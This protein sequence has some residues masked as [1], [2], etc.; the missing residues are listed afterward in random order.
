MKKINIL[1]QSAGGP[2]AVGFIKSLKEL[3]YDIKIVACD[4][5]PLASGL[6]LADEYHII[7]K[8]T[9]ES[10]GHVWEQTKLIIEEHDI[11]FLLPTSDH[12]LLIISTYKNILDDMDVKTFVS[13]R[14]VI[15]ICRDKFT[16]WEHLNDSFNMPNPISA[17]LEKPD[18]GCGSRGVNLI[19]QN[20]GCTLWEYLPGQEYTVDVFCDD[21]SNVICTS[22]RKRL[23]IKAGISVKGSIIRHS[24]IEKESNKLCK[25]LNIQGPC[26]IQWK[27]DIN[28]QPGLIECNPR[29]GGGTYI[30]SLAGANPGRIYLD[31]YQNKKVSKIIP[32]EITVTRYFEEII[33]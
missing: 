11:N 28:G 29:L 16:F 6:Y 22:V 33:I 23:G 15:D 17:V 27:E 8:V 25:K 19:T 26:C 1:V 14:K 20:E 4:C 13:S 21:E 3:D 7:D 10:I 9:D 32:K 18:V 24:L 5:D 31:L 2:A 12:D 30:T